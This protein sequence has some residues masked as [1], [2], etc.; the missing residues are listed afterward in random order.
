[1]T[2]R[3]NLHEA[4]DEAPDLLVVGMQRVRSVPVEE[5]AGLRVAHRVAMAADIAALLVNVAPAAGLGQD[6]RH[7]GT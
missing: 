3:E 4:L 5:H 6:A 7:D 1:V 2:V